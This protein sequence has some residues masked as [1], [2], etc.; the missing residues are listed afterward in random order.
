MDTIRILRVIEYIGPRDLVEE[1][2]KNSIHG[3]KKI[4][5]SG[6]GRR[7][8]TIRVATVNPFPDIVGEEVPRV[9]D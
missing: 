2:V 5:H 3:T 8:I 1:Q 7:G 6:D 9:E 4:V